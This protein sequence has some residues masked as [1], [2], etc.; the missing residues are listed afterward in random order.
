[1]KTPEAEKFIMNGTTRRINLF[2]QALAKVIDDK[3]MINEDSLEVKE[4]WKNYN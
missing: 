4:A 2:N 1:M 3:I